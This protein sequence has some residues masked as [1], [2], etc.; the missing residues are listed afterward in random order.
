MY[1]HPWRLVSPQ[2]TLKRPIIAFNSLEVALQHFKSCFQRLVNAYRLVNTSLTCVVLLR[3]Q[4]V[5]CWRFHNHQNGQVWKASCVWYGWL[6]LMMTW[7]ILVNLSLWSD[8][9]S[10]IFWFEHS[11]CCPFAILFYAL[12]VK[13]GKNA[14]NRPENQQNWNLTKIGLKSDKFMK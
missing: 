4:P 14:Q 2:N 7:F 8:M 10:S 5:I 9:F 11:I 6:Q 13:N 3:V 1:C 12:F